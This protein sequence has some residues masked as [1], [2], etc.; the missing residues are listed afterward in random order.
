[1]LEGSV[2]E[3]CWGKV[4]QRGVVDKCWRKVMEK[5]LERMLE[6]SVGDK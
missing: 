6:K 4:L 1:M 2:V 3:K 5:M